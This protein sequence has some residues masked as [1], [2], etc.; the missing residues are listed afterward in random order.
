MENIVY[1]PFCSDQLIK[2]NNH[3]FCIKGNCGFSEIVENEIL[4]A[5]KNDVPYNTSNDVI[6]NDLKSFYCPKCNCILSQEQNTKRCVCKNCKIHF[7]SHV[8]YHLIE[9]T[10]HL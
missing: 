9:H 3:L 7:P 8:L 4:N 2:K 5:I 6:L 1:C 10:G